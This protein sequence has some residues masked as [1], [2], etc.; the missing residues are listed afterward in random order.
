MSVSDPI[1]AIRE[2][3]NAAT[4]GPWFVDGRYA[5]GILTQR[6]ANWN[7]PHWIVVPTHAPIVEH[8]DAILIA[9]APTDLS[10]LLE[11]RDNV[12]NLHAKA[13]ATTL[14]PYCRACTIGMFVVAY[15]CATAR[16][17]GVTDAS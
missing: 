10:Y 2:R 3:L 1:P 15:P 8:T 14:E 9:H 7:A 16:A 17:L 4:P 5:D 11:Q 13:W 12:L 6:G